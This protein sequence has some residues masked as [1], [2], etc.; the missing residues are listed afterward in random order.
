MISQTVM[1]TVDSAMVGHVGKTELAAVGLGGIF[2][3]TLYSF[4]IGLTSAVNTFVAQSFGGGDF[5]RCGV[6]LWQGLYISLG[7]AVLI[8]VVRYFVP[9]IMTLLGPSEP[10]RP[11]ATS[12]SQIRMIS[13]PFF[14]IYY[15]YSHFYRGIGDTKTPL[16]V[17]LL[18]HVVNLAGDYLLI[19]GKGPFPE[20][21]VEGAA[22]ATTIANFVAAA[23]FLGLM[24]I[25]G[26]QG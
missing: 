25:I 19:Y 12:Y 16:K 8:Y 15:T 4:F 21:G 17:L 18:A 5:R 24:F 1:W 20:M 11:L 22:W 6:Y 3:F 10:V 7:A 13:A 14:L 2:V 9:E 26:F 23:A